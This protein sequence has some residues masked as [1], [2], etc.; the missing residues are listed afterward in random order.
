MFEL[1]ALLAVA[2]VV[3]AVLGVL[4]LV[5]GVVKLA[6]KIVLLPLKLLFIPIAVIVGGALLIAAIATILPLLIVAGLFA[7]PIALIAAIA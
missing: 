4:F 6:F 5:L 3:A 7:I 1:L 2:G